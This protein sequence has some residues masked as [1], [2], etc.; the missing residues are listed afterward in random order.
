MKASD[1]YRCSLQL[2]CRGG[3]NPHSKSSFPVPPSSFRIAA[4]LSAWISAETTALQQEI[5][6]RFPVLYRAMMRRS[7]MRLVAAAREKNPGAHR[8]E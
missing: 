4:R 3:E 5:T 7:I 6:T 2:D 1:K 8:T